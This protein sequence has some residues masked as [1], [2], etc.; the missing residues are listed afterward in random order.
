MAGI[1][2][3]PIPVIKP[4]ST[5]LA[6]T[7]ADILDAIKNAPPAYRQMVDEHKALQKTKSDHEAVLAANEKL[8]S[9]HQASRAQFAAEQKK[10]ADAR[11][12]HTKDMEAREKAISVKDS[13]LG[14]RDKTIS[15]RE[16][17]CDQRD[18]DQDARQEK[19]AGFDISMKKREEDVKK[20]WEDI[21]KKQDDIKATQDRLEAALHGNK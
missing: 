4:G 20:A 13:A 15:G 2:D 18:K 9:E 5:E 11:N 8:M 7:F 16:R 17:A 19:Q 14:M 6:A 3:T 12:V 1:S 10:E 21:A